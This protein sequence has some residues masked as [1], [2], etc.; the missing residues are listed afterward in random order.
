MPG[1]IVGRTVDLDGKP[2]FT[3]TLQAR[4]QHIR[5]SKATSN[6]CTNQGLLVTAGD[7]LPVAAR[8]RRASR[9]SPLRRIAAHHAARRGA[10]A[11]PGREAAR[12]TGPRFHEAVLQLDRPV[13]AG[14]R[15]ARARAASSAATT[16]RRTTR[17]SATR[18]SSARPRRAPTPTSRPMPARSPRCSTAGSGRLSAGD[19]AMQRKADLRALAPGR[20]ADASTQQAAAP[21][22]RSRRRSGAAQPAAAA[23]SV[24]AAGSAPLHAAVAA[25]L[26]HRHALLPARVVHDEVQPAGLQPV[27]DAAGVPRPPSARAGIDRARASSQCMYELQEMLKEVTGMQRRVA[28]ADGRRAGRV[29]RRG[30][31]PRLPPRARRP[32]AQRDH[33]AGRGARHQSG[34]RD[35]VRLHG[36]GDSVAA[37]R[38]HRR[39]GAASAAVGPQTAGI[40]LTNPSTLG[41]FERRIQRGREASCT[42]RAACC[43]TTAP[44]STR[45]SARCARAT[46]GSTSS[47]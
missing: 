21:R 13:G 39:R 30:D 9:A 7:D 12:S 37:E 25:Q 24:G 27:R 6:I 15:G 19:V 20:S 47:T 40:M 5:R 3:L 22:P 35:D 1:R 18:C 32:R 44:T 14:A 29:R 43:T 38:R 4:E 46:W 23:G 26:L 41:V 36:A 34:H 45:S 17:S 8:R 28:H 16:S 31:D 33:R 2:G 42:R 11:H 10:D